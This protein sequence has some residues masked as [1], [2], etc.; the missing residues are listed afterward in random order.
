MPSPEAEYAVT[1]RTVSV[2]ETTPQT[3]ADSAYPVFE[4]Q[5]TESLMSALA[6]RSSQGN[7]PPT[8]RLHE[9]PLEGRGSLDHDGEDAVSVGLDTH[10]A[11]HGA[12]AG[13]EMDTIKGEVVGITGTGSASR[14]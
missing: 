8:A 2:C 12:G 7:E 4:A 5:H 14:L 1:L 9:H 11:E 6:P 13:G 3:A 10:T